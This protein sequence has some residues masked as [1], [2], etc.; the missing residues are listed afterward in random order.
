MRVLML[1]TL[2]LA[3]C[4]S[5]APKPAEQTPGPSPE[6]KRATDLRA[7]RT[8][9]HR[10]R[11]DLATTDTD[12]VKAAKRVTYFDGTK[13]PAHY[14][15]AT[16][17]AKMA[18]VRE[19]LKERRETMKMVEAYKDRNKGLHQ[20]LSVLITL[21]ERRIELHGRLQRIEDEIASLGEKP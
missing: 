6:E 5:D 15:N 2:L 4:G 8:Q 10:V 18:A 20:Q 3:G 21:L 17:V 16:E 11:K 13:I 19:E 9:Q 14:L 7:L 1:L 12:L